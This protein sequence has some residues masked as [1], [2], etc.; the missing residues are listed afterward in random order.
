MIAGA[1]LQRIAQR[2]G[3]LMIPLELQ[4]VKKEGQPSA[5]T[6][7][8]EGLFDQL[9]PLLEGV[10][11]ARDDTFDGVMRDLR[12]LAARSGPTSREIQILRGICRRA[13]RALERRD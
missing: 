6:D 8:I 13:Q 3:R 10:G 4:L 1:D 2:S 5:P 7:E 12:H 11:F 9:T